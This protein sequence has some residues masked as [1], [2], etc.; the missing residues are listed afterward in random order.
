VFPSSQQTISSATVSQS[1]IISP[2][3]SSVL[4]ISSSSKNMNHFSQFQFSR[5]SKKQNELSSNAH[6]VISHHSARF[7]RVHLLSLQISLLAG[8]LF[9]M[10]V[11]VLS[12]LSHPTSKMENNNTED[13]T[14]VFFIV[15]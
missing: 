10:M 14:S 7:V 4:T 9:S 3:S 15:L 2:V 5:S 12:F 11:S 1:S 8:M 6:T 13:K